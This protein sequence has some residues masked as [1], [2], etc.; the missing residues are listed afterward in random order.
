MKNL[1]LLICFSSSM[2]CA[3]APK[4]K[5]NISPAIKQKIV[6]AINYNFDACNREDI[7]DVMD[8]CADSMPRREEFRAETLR[9]FREKDI[10]YSLVEVEVLEIKGDFA[11]VR[12]VQKSHMDDRSSTIYR[13]QT[14]LV[15]EEECVEYLNTL[16]LENGIWKLHS[17]ISE[18][19][20]VKPSRP[21]GKGKGECAN[22]SCSRSATPF[23]T[24]NVLKENGFNPPKR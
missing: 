22:G 5:R 4:A 3:Q 21:E 20:P 13:N 24:S 8:S 11:L 16:R 17:I 10:H 6:E 23:N 14:A 2:A 1:L 19:K 9:V 12:M 18:M 7:D 15:T